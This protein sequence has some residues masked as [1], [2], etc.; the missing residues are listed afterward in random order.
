MYAY[1]FEGTRFDAG[2]KLGYL[3]AIIAFGMRHSELGEEF[4]KYIKEIDT[5]NLN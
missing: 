2:D 4:R 3:K 1:E 5:D